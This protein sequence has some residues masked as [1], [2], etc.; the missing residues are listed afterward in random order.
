MVSIM[1]RC[2]AV[3]ARPLTYLFYLRSPYPPVTRCA[4]SA[5]LSSLSISLKTCALSTINLINSSYSMS[6]SPF[7]SISRYNSTSSQEVLFVA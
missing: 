4:R 1:F 5:I 7:T 2:L 6:P 3:A